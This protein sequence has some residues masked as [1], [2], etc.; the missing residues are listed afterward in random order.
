[1]RSSVLNSNRSFYVR[2][3]RRLEGVEAAYKRAVPVHTHSTIAYTSVH[4][5]W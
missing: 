2:G 4:V 1:M 5:H 3:E